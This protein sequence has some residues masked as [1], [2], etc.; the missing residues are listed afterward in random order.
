MNISYNIYIWGG[1]TRISPE[2]TR[3]KRIT[4]TQLMWYVVVVLCR[5][6]AMKIFAKHRQLSNINKLDEKSCV[7][8]HRYSYIRTHANRGAC[9]NIF[10]YTPLSGLNWSLHFRLMLMHYAQATKCKCLWMWHTCH[11]SLSLSLSLSLVI[12]IRII[13]RIINDNDVVDEKIKTSSVIL[14]W[15]VAT[16]GCNNNIQIIIIIIMIIIIVMI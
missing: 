9:I 7:R 13:I 16:H 12:M 5:V 11:M 14:L 15:A 2:T 8:W 4:Q 1:R 6:H 10:I 3:N